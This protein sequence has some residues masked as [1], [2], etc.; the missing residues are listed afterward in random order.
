MTFSEAFEHFSA[1]GIASLRRA[2]FRL[3]Q[4]NAYM[5]IF[6]GKVY[7]KQRDN[8]IEVDDTEDTGELFKEIE[9]A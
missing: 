5:A 1:G 3:A 4:T 6:L 7:L 2:Q 8:T 9:N